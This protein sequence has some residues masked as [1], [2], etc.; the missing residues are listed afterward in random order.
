MIAVAGMERGIVLNKN[1][2]LR[3]FF[4]KHA[5]QLTEEWY[6]SIEDNDPD[7]SQSD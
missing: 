2:A 6:E 5:D 4:L 1:E 3:M 7:R